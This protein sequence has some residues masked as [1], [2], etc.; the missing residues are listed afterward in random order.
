[1]SYVRRLHFVMDFQSRN[2][3]TTIRY[4][5]GI[6]ENIQEKEERFHFVV[7]FKSYAG[8]PHFVMDFQSRDRDTILR[9]I[10][11]AHPKQSIE[12]RTIP[13]R[14]VFHDLWR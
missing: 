6:T 2:R 1:M 4:I 12:I 13:F 9:Y 11:C 8:R 14:C 5:V 7:Y 10:F 3:S